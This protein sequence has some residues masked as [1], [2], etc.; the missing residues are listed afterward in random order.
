MPTQEMIVLANSRK[1]GGR[2]VAGISLQ[3]EEWVRPVSSRPEGELSPRDCAIDGRPPRTLDVVRFQ[4]RRRLGDLAQPENVLID[5]GDW[6]L[7]GEVEPAEAYERLRPYLSPGPGLLGGTEKGVSE[8]AVAQ[9]GLKAS[10]ALV[11]PDSIE[12]VSREPFHPGGPRKARAVFEL[13][14]QRWDLG[15]TDSVVAPPLR[16]L[17][18]GVYSP[19]DL[20]FPT[21]GHILLTISITEPLDG[22]RWK[23]APAVHLLA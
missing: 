3:S 12:F 22:M 1:M 19:T 11:E 15:I 14:S 10:L 18:S 5:G 7:L 6:E 16:R 20:G 2:C 8:A 9:Q 23:L 13:R 4:Y 21:P 17:E